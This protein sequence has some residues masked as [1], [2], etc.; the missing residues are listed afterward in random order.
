M[1]VSSNPRCGTGMADESG[2]GNQGGCCGELKT[3]CRR[4]EHQQT[5]QQREQQARAPHQT[6]ACIE[7]HRPG[8]AV[9][10][11]IGNG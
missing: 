2:Q 7:Q 11:N 10:I 3:P 4:P 6:K 8:A 1:T 5:E 9:Q